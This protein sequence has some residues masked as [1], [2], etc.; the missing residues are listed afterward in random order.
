VSGGK[1]M[2][3]GSKDDGRGQRRIS[4]N[5]RGRRHGSFAFRAPSSVLRYPMSTAADRFG[6]SECCSVPL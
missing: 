5:L 3:I 4:S 2:D 6:L 1:T